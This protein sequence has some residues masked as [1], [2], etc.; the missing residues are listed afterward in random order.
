MSAPLSSPQGNSANTRNSASGNTLI[1]QSIFGT[2]ERHSF[3]KG[4]LPL[5][6]E[7]VQRCDTIKN[8]SPKTRP[9]REIVNQLHAG[10]IF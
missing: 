3:S 2:K 1:Y 8:V 10:N 5:K 9:V 4:K 6:V 7:I